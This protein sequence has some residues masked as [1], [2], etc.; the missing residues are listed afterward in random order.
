M[1]VVGA[2][3]VQAV[4]L[5][6]A[7]GVTVAGGHHRDHRLALLD[8]P[9]TQLDVVGRHARGV[10]ARGLEAQQFLHGILV[11][12]VFHRGLC[13][14]RCGARKDQHRLARI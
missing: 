5:G 7:L 4:G 11:A 13:T 9:A 8:L 14:N 3:E 10:L 2:A 6:E 1:A 12:H